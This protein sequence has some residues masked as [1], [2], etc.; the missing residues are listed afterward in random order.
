MK[1][2][3]TAIAIMSSV[4]T[5]P[6]WAAIYTPTAQVGEFMRQFEKAYRAGDQ[7]WIRSAVDKDGI[8]E[9]VKATF[10]GFLG[11]KEGGESIA[12]LKAIA[13]PADYKLPNSLIDTEIDST[14]P[15]D[16]ILIFTRKTGDF[17]T[18]IKVPVGYREGKIW[19][20]GIKKK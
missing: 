6:T 9:E 12:D 14:I 18:T 13:A 11:P 17:E 16:F 15:V 5:A 20:V 3:I 1:A 2:I 10:F 8:A 4:S 19:L 7:E